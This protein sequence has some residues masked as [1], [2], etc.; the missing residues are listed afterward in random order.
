MLPSVAI[1]G[2]FGSGKTTLA[3]HLIENHGYTRVSFAARLKEVA[4]AVYGDGGPIEKPRIYLATS[5]QDVTRPIT[6]R[7]L[8]QELG[9][10]V[11]VLD[12]DFWIKWLAADIRA[13]KYG[14]GPFVIDDCRFPYEAD[15][16]RD[17]MGFTVVRLDV[18]E[19][20][21]FARYEALYG[22]APSEA[23][24]NHPSETE[25][26]LIR[27]DKILNGDLPAESVAAL[28]VENLL[29]EDGAVHYAGG[30]S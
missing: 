5:L 6:G 24:I 30:R 21:R 14:V 1:V 4:A 26:L 22:Y 11:K 12:R 17:E 9:Q 23:E 15:F 10:S 8:L 25:V 18:P 27:P 13:G 29:G 7:M 2:Q 16:L 20:V 28:L 19:A 3:N